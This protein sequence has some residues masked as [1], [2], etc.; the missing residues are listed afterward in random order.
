METSRI[1][2]IGWR[3]GL[4]K[5]EMTKT[6]RRHT[7]LDLSEAKAITDAVLN[8]R[9]ATVEVADEATS[10]LLR[11]ELSTLGAVVSRS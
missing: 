10:L 11:E 2:I 4:L 3:E 1:K 6:I 9:A 5:I 8:G 7:D